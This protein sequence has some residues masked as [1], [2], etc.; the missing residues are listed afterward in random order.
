LSVVAPLPPL[1]PELLHAVKAAAANTDTAA[2][3]V[4]TR[5]MSVPLRFFP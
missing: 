1:P 4:A 3:A 2:T 5:L